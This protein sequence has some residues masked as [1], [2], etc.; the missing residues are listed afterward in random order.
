MGSWQRW[1]KVSRQHGKLREVDE[2]F[3]CC[4]ES[5]RKIMEI[6]TVPWNVDG[7][8]S[9]RPEISQKLTECLSIVRNVDKGW[10]KFSWLHIKLMEGLLAA[11]KFYGSW[12]KIFWPQGELKKVDGKSASGTKSWQKLTQGLPAKRKLMQRFLTGGKFNRN[13][14]VTRLHKNFMVKGLAAIWKFDGKS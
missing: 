14:Q 1:R 7:R 9:G 11:R 10:W 4:T 5:W 13:L 3:F 8:S 2:R 12:R 6:H